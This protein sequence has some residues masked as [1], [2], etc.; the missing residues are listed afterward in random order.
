MKIKLE[1]GKAG[2]EV[3]FPETGF[4]LIEPRFVAGLPDEA[5]ALT[6]ALGNP[7]GA[8]PLKEM[9]VAGDSVAIV[10][11]DRTRAM[12]SDRVLPVLLS[13]LQHVPKEKITLINAVGT[14]RENTREEL[15]AMVGRKIVEDYRIVQHR[16]K[17]K[18]SMVS[19]GK[20]SFGHNIWV[21]RDFM[22]AKVKILTGFIEPHFFAG[23]SGGPKAVLLGVGAF[24][25]ILQ[26]HSAPML[27]NPYST[28]GE[29]ARN[30]IYQEMCEIAALARPDFIVNVTLNR[31]RQITG[32]FAGDWKQAHAQGCAFA[33]ECVM[34]PVP[35][36]FDIVITTNSGFP[37]DMNLYQAVKGM[38][39]AARIVKPGGT[40]IIAAECA[41]GIPPEGN[42]RHL[43]HSRTNPRELLEMVRSFKDP[44]HD[45]W[46]VQIL[47]QI[48]I[49]ANVYLFSALPEEEV[50]AAHLRPV[51]DIAALVR[52]LQRQIGPACR[53]AILPEGPQTVPVL[54]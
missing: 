30:P 42:F 52:Q 43:L 8:R 34:R 17:D 14:H 5:A 27:D 11:P 21:N 54:D 46:E 3:D 33:R 47:A 13:E 4:D 29:T 22:E 2:L 15:E 35:A 45:Q 48:L 19:L 31:H 39:G 38:S 32:I 49:K 37:L 10:F 50:T 53:I 18:N 7:I 36:P 26:N 6:A 12:P 20:S 41:D 44:V 1:Y 28:W 16:P 51:K 40:I 25:S 24:E 9:A 23:F